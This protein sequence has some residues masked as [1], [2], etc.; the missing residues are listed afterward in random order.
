MIRFSVPDMTCPGC[1]GS[2]TRAVQMLDPAAQVVAD[3][4]HHTV[5]I[6]SAATAERLAAA[7]TDAGFTILTGI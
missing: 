5:E 6:T 7:I 4:E 2:I 1:V 3:I